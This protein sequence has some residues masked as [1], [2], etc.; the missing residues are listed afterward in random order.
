MSMIVYFDY[1]ILDKESV[2][3]QGEIALE[4]YY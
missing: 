2:G 4:S 1:M 3:K